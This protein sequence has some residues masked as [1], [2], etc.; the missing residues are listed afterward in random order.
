MKLTNDEIQKIEK[1]PYI[2]EIVI[3]EPNAKNPKYFMIS[4]PR[5]GYN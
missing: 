2:I 5:F 4:P 3:A 1:Y